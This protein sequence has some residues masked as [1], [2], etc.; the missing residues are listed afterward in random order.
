MTVEEFLKAFKNQIADALARVSKRYSVT[1][2]EWTSALYSSARKYLPELVSQNKSE[3]KGHGEGDGLTQRVSELLGSINSD[4]LCLAVACAKGDDAAWTDFM[5]DYRSYLVSIA[6]SVTQEL[7][8]AEQLADSAF[9]E[10]Y[11][12]RESAGARVSKFSFYSGRGSL[13]GWLRAVVYQLS[14]DSYRKTGRFVQTEE[15]SDMERLSAAADVHQK[16]QIEIADSRYQTAVAEA[17][18]KAINELDSKERL[19]LAHYYYDEFT[20]KEIGKLFGVHEATVCRWLAKVQ[21]RIRKLV[22][23][24]LAR[25]HHFNRRQ[26]AEAVELAAEAGQ[27]NLGD[28]LLEASG[29]HIEPVESSEQ[30]KE[31]FSRSG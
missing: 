24:S 26:V 9:A 14:A 25:D 21:K 4:D 22:E 7:G 30:R 11:G 16:P 6:R 29:R 12:L 13:R 27:V 19:L 31:A 28:Y 15:Q 1:D 8:A 2:D 5:R 18:R 23:K 17:L 10:L 20:L 3:A